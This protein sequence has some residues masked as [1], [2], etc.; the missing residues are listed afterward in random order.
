M[1]A[2]RMVAAFDVAM[3]RNDVDPLLRNKIINDAL[4]I[5]IEQIDNPST[6]YPAEFRRDQG[7]R[8]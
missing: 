7:T 2:L 8:L 4:K 5:A 6:V 3:Q 1:S